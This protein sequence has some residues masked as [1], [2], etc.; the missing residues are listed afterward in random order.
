TADQAVAA[1]KRTLK[2]WLGHPHLRVVD[3]STNLQGKMTRLIEHINA[4]LGV[5]NLEFER[6][7]L[8][9]GPP[10]LTSDLLIDAK[11][12]HI[13]QTYLLSEQNEEVRVRKWADADEN[14]SYFWTKKKP[15]ATGGREEREAL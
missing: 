3:N 2:A 6:R 4:S 11:E 7:Y 15:L 8:L 10:D 12:I 14:V 13:E 5:S 1:D 9:S